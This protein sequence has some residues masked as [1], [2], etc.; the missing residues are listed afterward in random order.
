VAERGRREYAEVMRRRY[1]EATRRQRGGILDEY[2]RVTRCQRKAA[3]RRLG[4]PAR[5]RGAPA[6]R[7]ARYGRELLPLLERLRR[8]SDYLSGKLLRPILPAL[9]TALETH[10]G[11]VVA[12]PARTALLA[13]SPRDPGPAAPAPAPPPSRPA[14]PQRP[15]LQRVRAQVPLRTWSEWG[16]V[17]PGA[18]QGDLVLHCGETLPDAACALSLL[19]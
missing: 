17:A 5:G 8:A 13:G 14:P 18:L 6:W 19:R 12:P 3:I 11:V 10:H 15:G 9:V 2:C 16:G 7:P 4:A 1:Q